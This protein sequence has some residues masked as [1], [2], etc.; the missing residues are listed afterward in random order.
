[1]RW[2][3]GAL[4]HSYILDFLSVCLSSNHIHLSLQTPHL[5]DYPSWRRESRA[6]ESIDQYHQ[7]PHQD[8]CGPRQV[9]NGNNDRNKHSFA[10]PS[11][12]L[13]LRGR[14]MSENDLRFDSSHRWS[15][16]ISVA[17]SQTLSEVE[18]GAGGVREGEAANTAQSRKKTP[19]PPRPPPPKWEQFHRRRA[20]HHTLFP[21]FSS[22]APHSI[23]PTFNTTEGHYSTHVS[24]YI[25]PLETSRQRSYSLPPERQEVLESCP[26]CNCSQSQTQEQRFT[27]PSSNQIPPRTQETPFAHAPS[28][29]NPA[30]FQELPFTVTPPSPMSSRRSFR[31]VAPPQRERD[32]RSTYGEQQELLPSLPP[33]PP[34]E[35]SASR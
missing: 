26:R 15:P 10:P 12:P 14:A 33:P 23:T 7:H 24:S 6:P 32:P 17:T 19:P 16:S 11:V 28:N 27:H 13:S 20:S 30:Q 18:E 34:T 29:Q 22:T 25:P 9:D 4:M 2:A 31:P 8:Q 3:F 35:N 1:M 5:R 21:S